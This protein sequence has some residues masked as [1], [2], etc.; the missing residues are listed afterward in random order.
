VI[1][2]A[3]TEPVVPVQSDNARASRLD[4]FDLNAWA[5]SQLM[6]SLNLLRLADQLAHLGG[7]AAP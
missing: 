1:G 5:N 6:Q 2:F 7:L 3:K 4:H